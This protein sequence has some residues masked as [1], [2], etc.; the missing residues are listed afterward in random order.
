MTTLVGDDIVQEETAVPPTVVPLI[1][2][3]PCSEVMKLE[4]VTV[5]L[6]LT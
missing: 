6:L 2:L 4:P 1:Q 3:P 5:M